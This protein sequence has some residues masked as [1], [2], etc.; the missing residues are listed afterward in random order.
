MCT[1]KAATIN[2]KSMQMFFPDGQLTNRLLSVFISNVIITKEQKPVLFL[3]NQRTTD[4]SKKHIF[5]VG[6]VDFNQRWP[7]TEPQTNGESKTVSEEGTLLIFDVSSFDIALYRPFMHV[8]PVIK[9]E[10]KD[11]TCL[12]QLSLGKKKANVGSAKGIVLNTLFL[13]LGILIFIVAVAARSQGGWL[14]VVD[15]LCEPNGK[16]SL[17]KVQMAVWTVVIVAIVYAF[18]LSKL[19]IPEIPAT[20]LLLMGASYATRAMVKWQG[21][22]PSQETLDDVPATS[23]VKVHNS[24]R[25]S[26]LICDD[27]GKLSLPRAQMLM[28][29]VLSVVLFIMKSLLDGHMWHVPIELVFL[30]GMSQL[31]YAIPSMNASKKSELSKTL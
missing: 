21:G 1:Q 8:T 24:P 23:T 19:T 5:D 22:K 6:L 26:H 29:T 30:M 7:H 28:W 18:S 14:Q 11:N 25:L 9:W 2:N 3:L 15:L 27:S 13:L 16:L 20:L 4:A 10:N 31:G 17:S 12:Q